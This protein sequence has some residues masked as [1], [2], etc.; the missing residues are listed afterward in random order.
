MRYRLTALVR[1]PDPSSRSMPVP[2]FAIDSSPILALQASWVAKSLASGRPG[3]ICT[4]HVQAARGKA[5]SANWETLKLDDA[6]F[7]DHLKNQAK[8]AK[9]GDSS[10]YSLPSLPFGMDSLTLSGG[11]GSKAYRRLRA[12]CPRLG[13]LLTHHNPVWH[14]ERASRALVPHSPGLYSPQPSRP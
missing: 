11:S 14:R 10:L 13:G 6:Y 8:K 7:V 2:M 1:D 5:A 12:P 9:V 3:E 4:E